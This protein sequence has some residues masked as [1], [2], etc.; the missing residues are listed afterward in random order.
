M[1]LLLSAPPH[2]Q[3]IIHRFQVQKVIPEPLVHLVETLHPP[4]PEII[5]FMEQKE[6]RQAEHL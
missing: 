1:D 6:L 5:L 2:Q 4:H 3:T